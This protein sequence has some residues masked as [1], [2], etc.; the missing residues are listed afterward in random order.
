MHTPTMG[1][2]LCGLLLGCAAGDQKTDS[3]QMWDVCGPPVGATTIGDWRS[4][5]DPSLGAALG[6]YAVTPVGDALLFSTGASLYR[7]PQAG[8]PAVE[9]QQAGLG[10][11]GDL[12]L[13][14]DGGGALVR[15]GLDWWRY[16]ADGG[17]ARGLDLPIGYASP[18]A[19]DAS[20]QT[21]WATASDATA[22]TVRVVQAAAGD[23]Q[24]TVALADQHRGTYARWL[25]AAD[26]SLL[27]QGGG[28]QNFDPTL[29]RFYLGQAQAVATAP[30]V[31]T[32]LGVDGGR[33]L[34]V[35]EATPGQQGG[36]YA[37][38]VDG[39]AATLLEATVGAARTA[40]P[41]ADGLLLVDDTTLWRVVP[42][43]GV[44]ALAALPQGG[45]AHGALA[46]GQGRIFGA[47]QRLDTEQVILWAFEP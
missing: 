9:L 2:A 36:L 31:G 15:S 43:G 11:N 44:E 14:G 8:G 40:W 30:P 41:S 33:L 5:T 19:W 26:G 7:Q 22:G 16:P 35:G 1:A 39:G 18:F 23:S 25:R 47:T 4:F 12:L 21:L 10:A 45:C 24:A 6:V 17:P 32:L 38:A 46:G 20:T 42:D 27:T 28:A 3:G 34:Y 37:R 29:Y 13:W